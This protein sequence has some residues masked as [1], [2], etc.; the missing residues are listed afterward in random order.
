[1]PT[2]TVEIIILG[3]DQ[4][5][6]TLKGIGSTVGNVGRGIATGVGI[7]GMALADL[8]RQ[9]APVEAI[10]QA[11]RGLADA[12]D[13]M[14]A[15]LQRG[16]AG[17]ITQAD[18][19]ERY[20]L[21]AQ[22]VG[23]TFAEQLPDALDY[24]GKVSLSTGQD[25][26]FLLD[27][28]V[29]GVGRL[30]PM[31]LDNLAVQIDLN[32]AYEQWAD[33]NGVAVSEMSKADQQAA[34]M[35]ETLR[36]LATNT[37]KLPPLTGSAVQQMGALTTSFQDTKIAIGQ[38][39]L[40]VLQEVL[41]IFSKLAEDIGPV[42]IGF[43]QSLADWFRDLPEPIQ[44]ML[45]VLVPLGAAFGGLS[46]VLAPLATL[47][48][49]IGGAIGALGAALG[50][51]A[52]PI[53]IVIAIVAALGL[54][55]TTNF[56]GIRD[57]VTAI[58]E[59][60][61]Q[62]IL[63]KIGEVLNWLASVILPPLQWA[64]A[65]AWAFIQE[66]IAAA[67]AA[68]Q[69]HLEELQAVLAEF[70]EEI[71][72]RLQEAWAAIQ[73]AMQLVQEWIANTL[74]PALQNLWDRLEPV[75]EIVIAVMG[76]FISFMASSFISGLKVWLGAI[77]ALWDGVSAAISAV[78]DLI[79][80][81]MTAVQNAIEAWRRFTSVTGGGEAPT[82]GSPLLQTGLAY[83]PRSPYPAILHRGEAVLTRGQAMEWRRQRAQAGPSYTIISN[84]DSVYGVD[85][86]EEA[87]DEAVSRATRYVR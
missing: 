36:Q 12:P 34:V 82:G 42:L 46:I 56:L 65:T 25:M 8:A 77:I 11:F 62:P 24:L 16:S 71:Q 69:P 9:A 45:A 37:E 31:I 14:L 84:I 2:R 51:L 10:E 44:T 60:V 30:S 59:N 57:I 72:P 81:F 54:A 61:L 39:F 87:L 40:P 86:I 85:G 19:M 74:I 28:L 63:T 23:E 67:W 27:S 66:V 83:V 4:L 52:G 32:A 64:F 22:L 53:G 15:A 17:M 79:G 7:A 50:A 21:A 70:W 5:S 41:P 48:P 68:I 55:W 73:I 29:R 47:I 13:E 33:A 58:W 6:G 26:G 80:G 78:I 35:A 1:V 76:A 43:V 18:L 75:R 20:N 38:A 49:V 3:K